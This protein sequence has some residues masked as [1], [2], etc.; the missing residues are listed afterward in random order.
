VID[1]LRVG[2]T[3]G[4]GKI[5][6]M[7]SAVPPLPL[8]EFD[9]DREAYVQ[10]ES[11]IHA[12]DAP[13]AA[14][15]CLFPEVVASVTAGG[16]KLLTLPSREPLWEITYHG[17]RLTVFYPG[18]GAPLAGYSLERAIAAGG[19]AIVAC[20]AAGA[21]V[22]DLAMGHHVIVVTGAVRDEGTS[23]HYQP[24]SHAITADPAIVELLLKTASDRGLPSI[25]GVT[26]TTDGFFRET[27]SRV[28]RRRKEG[29][30]TVE[31]EAAA[32]LAV[33]RFRR[34]SFGQYLYAGDDLSGEVWEDR[35]WRT[36]LDVRRQLFEL[37]AEAAIALYDLAIP[38]GD[39]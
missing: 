10:P 1:Q 8:L 27:P 26:W 33:A 13:P 20:G 19:R 21:L 6:C 16:R 7:T 14:V 23:F 11:M 18:I 28:A 12:V 39:L 38:R 35:N 30:I 37:A 4:H 29:C 31:M 32:L 2:Q 25:G 15:A 17:R 5:L 36:A 22:P 34:V 3:A 9:P 24:P